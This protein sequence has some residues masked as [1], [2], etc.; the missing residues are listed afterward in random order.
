M[1][2]MVLR[3]MQTTDGELFLIR[4]KVWKMTTTILIKL[5]LAKYDVRG[6]PFSMSILILTFCP[7]C[8]F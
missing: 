3:M 5:E 6:V 7:N 2:I 4:R 1:V 8:F